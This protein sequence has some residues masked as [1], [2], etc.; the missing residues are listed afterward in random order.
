[1]GSSLFSR[2]ARSESVVNGDGTSL[3]MLRQ[4]GRAC[5]ASSVQTGEGS[6]QFAIAIAQAFVVGHTAFSTTANF[7]D[8]VM[9]TA[10]SPC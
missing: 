9:T 7:A 8:G 2:A 3:D 1:M 10:G 5:F 6:S 4:P